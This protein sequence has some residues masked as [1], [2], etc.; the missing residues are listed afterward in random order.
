MADEAAKAKAVMNDGL[1][2][3]TK[4]GPINNRMQLARVEGLVEDAKA[5]GARLVAGGNRFSPNGKE[6]R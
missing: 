4:F 3:D 6:V 2:E 5:N 1:L